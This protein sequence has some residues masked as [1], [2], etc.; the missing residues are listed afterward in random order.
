MKQDAKRNLHRRKRRALR[1]ARKAYFKQLK[2]PV[3]AGATPEQGM[4]APRREV[5]RGDVVE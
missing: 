2:Q 5:N 3:D 1:L 4:T